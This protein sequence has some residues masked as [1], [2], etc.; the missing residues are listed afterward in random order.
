MDNVIHLFPQ[1]DSSADDTEII[2]AVTDEAQEVEAFERP[3]LARSARNLLMLIG[4]AL[5]IGAFVA[6][7][8]LTMGYA[9]TP[10]L[11]LGIAGAAGAALYVSWRYIRTL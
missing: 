11:G 6:R 4:A 8:I 7:T 5:V 2:D 10:S 9:L 3:S 1:Q